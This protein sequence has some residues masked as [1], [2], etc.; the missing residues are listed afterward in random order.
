MD[1]FATKRFYEANDNYSQCK[2]GGPAAM[3]GILLDN[4]CLQQQLA[5]LVGLKR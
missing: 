1:L 3:R 2:V 5:V 4:L